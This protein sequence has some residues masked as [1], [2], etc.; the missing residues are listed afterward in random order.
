[1]TDN[2]KP[3]THPETSSR[4]A[5]YR[6]DPHTGAVAVPIYPTTSFE[7]HDTGHA[8]NLFALTELG[9]FYT[10]IMNPTC[11]VLEPRVLAFEVGAPVLVASSGQAASAISI[12]N[13][14]GTAHT[15][16]SSTY[17]YGGP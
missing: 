6:S 13:I 12:Q 5:G 14:A 8:A 15:I 16:V 7:F 3:I 11:D 17:L 10:P 4:H 2:R 1:M 9:T